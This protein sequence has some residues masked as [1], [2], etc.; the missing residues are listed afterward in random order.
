M[1]LKIG[2]VSLGCPKNLVDSEVMMGQLSREG[3]EI[4]ADRSEA[5]I[6]VVNTCGFIEPA[7]EESIQNIL[8]MAEMKKSGR[9][10]KL[11]VAGCLAERYR[12]QV[13]KE[14]PEVDAVLGV[15]ELDQI[16]TLCTEEAPGKKP[17]RSRKHDP[18]PPRKLTTPGHSAYLKIAEGCGHECAFCVIPQIRGPHRS[19]SMS[20]ILR[21]AEQLAD[22]GVVELNLVSQDTT[23][24]GQDR[25]LEHGL[26]RLLEK[27]AQIPGVRWIRFL[28]AYPST[29][30]PAVLE[31][32][33]SEPKIC[34]Y[35][36]LP[37]QHASGRILH[38]MRRGGTRRSLERL[39]GRIRRAVPAVS[40]RT[41]MIVGYP[42]ETRE[43]FQELMDFCAEMRFE[44]LGVFL[45]SDEEETASFREKNKIPRRTMESRQMRLMTQQARISRKINRAFLGK[46]VEVLLDGVHPESEWLF[47]GRMAGQ[48]P[49][50]DG[51]VLI[52]E[53]EIP[54]VR[55]GCFYRV[56]ITQALDH[57]L[58][59]TIVT[60]TPPAPAEH[61]A[62]RSKKVWTEK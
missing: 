11:I 58:V 51:T 16:V 35:L 10:R 31:L 30:D 53:A 1:T 37:L 55:A 18:V 29:L 59:G 46:E 23:A 41:A 48:A 2:F 27:L 28:Y 24:Y 33:A 38:R 42:G 43:D 39:V 19:R 6:L 21:E 34:R 47:Q 52:N 12:P 13:R 40:L 57:D 50:I 62:G 4:T 45:Y 60:G 9:C 32:M 7:K 15:H 5:D 36:D 3:F 17:D 54:E 14:I 8:E 49:E 20:S 22:S 44:H 61:A 25:N 56:R 26:A